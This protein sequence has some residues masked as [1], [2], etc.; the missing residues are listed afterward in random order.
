MSWL[1]RATLLGAVWAI[2]FR[3]NAH[4]FKSFA[5]S[6]HAS[7]IFLPAALRVLMPLV[8]RSSGVFGL[9]L[10][11]LMI[12]PPT[13]QNYVAPLLFAVASGL[14]PVVGIAICNRIFKLPDDLTGLGAVHLAALSLLCGASNSFFVHLCLLLTDAPHRSALSVATI[15]FGDVAGTAIVLYALSATLAVLTPSLGPKD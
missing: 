15:F 11:S 8:Y 9:I 13:A 14:A 12:T 10:G 3:F 2:L 5:L 1:L 6:D 7:W 4:V